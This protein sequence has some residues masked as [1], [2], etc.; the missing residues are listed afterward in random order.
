M[1]AQN[2]MKLIQTLKI[3]LHHLINMQ[4]H[5]FLLSLHNIINSGKRSCSVTEKC[6]SHT[7]S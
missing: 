1:H 4:A 2:Q 5:N 3:V 6:G 7:S